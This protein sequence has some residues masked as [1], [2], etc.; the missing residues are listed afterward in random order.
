MV[1]DLASLVEMCQNT[2][3]MLATGGRTGMF[4]FWSALMFLATI[5]GVNIAHAQPSIGGSFVVMNAGPVAWPGTF[6]GCV[7]AAVAYGAS[8]AEA[9]R[10]CNF[11]NHG[12]D[13]GD[14]LDSSGWPMQPGGSGRTG[15]G[16]LNCASAG[17]N[18]AI[19]SWSN[20]SVRNTIEGLKGSEK[21]KN[22]KE[23]KDAVDRLEQAERLAE[24][25]FEHWSESIGTS[26]EGLAKDVFTAAAKYVGELSQIA[27]AMAEDLSHLLAPLVPK[28]SNGNDQQ[29]TQTESA[30]QQIAE[31]VAKCNGNGWKTPECKR[32][33]DRAT[34][35]GDP[36]VT[37]PIPAAAEEKTGQTRCSH[38]KADP[39]TVKK[40]WVVH[41]NSRIR[42]EPGADPCTPLQIEGTV[43]TF[44]LQPI[45]MGENE[46]KACGDPR[47]LI[48]P[49]KCIPSVT[50]TEFGE[51]DMEKIIA[52]IYNKAGG[53]VFM[54]PQ[55]R[56]GD[57]RPGTGPRGP[58]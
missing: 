36:M 49:A 38:P 2:L 41:C 21:Y 54:V 28:P 10:R 56:L 9:L 22:D 32:V 27:T 55:P 31:F 3:P 24:Q 18:P 42:P 6:R 13:R 51:R 25:A 26:S 5:F 29:R 23:F 58:K 40:A 43:H 45:V 44:L 11:D 48:D 46:N 34:A 37:D 12:W 30:C 4:P 35:C 47:A 20:S 7:I 50:L 39:E 16:S 15:T 53:P 8:V 33:I 57:P 19:S 17:A 52:E 14:A 1:Y